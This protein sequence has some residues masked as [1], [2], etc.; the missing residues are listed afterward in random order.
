MAGHADGWRRRGYIYYRGHF[1]AIS[2]RPL[3]GV[4]NSGYGKHYVNMQQDPGKTTMK[5]PFFGVDFFDIRM[6]LA[7]IF[8][9]SGRMFWHEMTWC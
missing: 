9:D 7:Y 6:I 2:S 8:V 5:F 1:A 3:L 4:K